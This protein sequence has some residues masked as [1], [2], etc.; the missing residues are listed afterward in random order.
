MPGTTATRLI[1]P[2]AGVL[3]NNYKSYSVAGIFTGCVNGKPVDF[4]SLVINGAE[5]DYTSTPL[6]AGDVIHLSTSVTTSG[7]TVQVTDVTTGVT[8]TL[9]G[10]GASASAAYIGDD[11]LSSSTGALLGV[12]N[13][14]TLTFTTCRIDGKAL[15]SRHPREYLRANHAGIVQIAPG[16]LSPDGT[17][18]PTYYNHS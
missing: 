13:A 3:V 4:P 6:T 9:T 18:F 8:K 7:T 15:A 2:D 11:P 12:P 1:A 17:A 5:T 10:A 14:G 16:A